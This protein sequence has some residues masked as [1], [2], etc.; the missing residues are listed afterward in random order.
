[1]ELVSA[2]DPHFIPGYTGFCPQY[3]YR[4]GDTYGTTTHKLLLDPTVHHAEKLVLSDRLADDYQVVRPPQRDIDIVNARAVTNDT[5]YKHPI[6]PG[7]EGFVPREHNLMGQRFTVQA[8]EA[9]AEFEK[10]QSA[11]KQALHELLRIGAV[12]DAKWYPN[13][14]SDRELTSTQF[15]LPLTDV[16]P[17]C[18]GILRN[19]P[20][21]EAPLTPPRHSPSPYFMDNTDPEK[22]FKK[23]FAGHVPFGYAAFGKTNEAMT[24]STLCDFT[25]NYR[26][27]LSTEWAPVTISR[28]DPPLLIKPTEIYHKHI[29]QLP[30]YGGH[31]PGAIFRFGKT[32]GNDSRDAKRWLRGDYN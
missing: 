13:T 4:I 10:L 24:N 1:M 29:G 16:R 21:V 6:I 20:Q 28:A 18:A 5:I 12:Q 23:G 30:N 15:K 11:D 14:L 31:I 22:Y 8:T 26:K 7:Y 9:L 2:P 17:E 32:Y 3:K 19:L 25:S 27:R